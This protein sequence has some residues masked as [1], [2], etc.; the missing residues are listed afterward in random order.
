[1]A[2]SM[3]DEMPERAIDLIT[4]QKIK[5][6]TQLVKLESDLSK[7]TAKEKRL[8]VA[9]IFRTAFVMLMTRRRYLKT[10]FG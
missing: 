3:F 6:G 8:S 5:P 9:C 10:T 7:P 4:D 2:Q 1:M